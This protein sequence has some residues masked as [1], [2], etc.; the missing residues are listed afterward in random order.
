MLGFTTLLLFVAN[1]PSCAW[2][3][4]FALG[5]AEENVL[6]SLRLR[7]AAFGGSDHHDHVVD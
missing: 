5:S 6:A 3:D 2:V 1:Q 7:L 4:E